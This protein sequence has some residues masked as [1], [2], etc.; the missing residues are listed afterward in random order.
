M[1]EYDFANQCANK[2]VQYILEMQTE[3]KAGIFELARLKEDIIEKC[4]EEYNRNGF[5]E[6]DLDYFRR[7]VMELY[8][9]KVKILS[10][11]SM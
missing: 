4:F 5:Y 10:E 6:I 3:N 9:E 7:L 1:G 8:Q 2:M 11:L